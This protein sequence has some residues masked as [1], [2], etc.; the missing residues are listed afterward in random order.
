[1][2]KKKLVYPYQE[3]LLSNKKE[4]RVICAII[5]MD[6]KGIVLSEKPISKSHILYDLI[7][8]IMEM[9]G[10]VRKVVGAG[11]KV[12]VCKGGLCVLNSLCLAFSGGPMNLHT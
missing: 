11:G 9:V 4:K 6:F 8:V 7:Q 2:V 10:M 1:M 12:W 3:I 5:W